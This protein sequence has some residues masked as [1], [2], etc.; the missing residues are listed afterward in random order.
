[1]HLQIVR[2]NCRNRM[3]PEY[4]SSKFL[5]LAPLPALTQIILLYSGA[6]SFF[7][8]F[9]RDRRVFFKSWPPWVV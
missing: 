4:F 9:L 6:Q 3:Y 7:W 1:M 8:M 2:G 5:V